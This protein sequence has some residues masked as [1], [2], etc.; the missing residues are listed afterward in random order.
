[1]AEVS[2]HVQTHNSRASL[3]AEVRWFSGQINDFSW[4]SGTLSTR[5]KG[6]LAMLRTMLWARR[7]Y[8]VLYLLRICRSSGEDSEDLTRFAGVAHLAFTGVC[9]PEVNCEC[10]RSRIAVRLTG[11]RFQPKLKTR[12]HTRGWTFLALS[13]ISKRVRTVPKSV[14]LLR[15][16]PSFRTYHRDSPQ[17]GFPRNF[18]LGT[19]L[20]KTFESLQILLQSG[21]SVGHFTWRPKY[22]SLLPATKNLLYK[23][24]C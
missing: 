11:R 3:I 21:R 13:V 12:K 4:I 23:H 10:Q 1:M 18:I 19:F 22:V 17:N 5:F 9:E 15:S 24:C 2:C 7:C 20:W 14:C 16:R 8:E 6:S